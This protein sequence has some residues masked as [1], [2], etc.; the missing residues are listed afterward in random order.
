MYCCNCNLIDMNVKI[1]VNWIFFFLLFWQKHAEAIGSS[2]LRQTDMLHRRRFFSRLCGVLFLSSFQT[3][4]TRVRSPVCLQ[5]VSSWRFSPG[6]WGHLWPRCW[7]EEKRTW[8]RTCQNLL[9]GLFCSSLLLSICEMFMWNI[10]ISILF[11]KPRS[12]CFSVD[13][14]ISV[15]C[16]HYFSD[17]KHFTLYPR[18]LSPIFRT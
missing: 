13:L 15:F 14:K 1:H 11:L 3:Q 9:W 4:V 12:C 10:F 6:C 18:K 5:P 2:A 16:K 7:M 8:R 17:I